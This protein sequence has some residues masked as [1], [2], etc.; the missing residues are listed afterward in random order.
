MFF[1][2]YRKFKK[3]V[4]ELDEVRGSTVISINDEYIVCSYGRYFELLSKESKQDE[5]EVFDLLAKMFSSEDGDKECKE[6][7]TKQN[8]DSIKSSKQETGQASED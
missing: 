8:K 2:G 7:S 4:K 6:D 1:S 3:F 5:R